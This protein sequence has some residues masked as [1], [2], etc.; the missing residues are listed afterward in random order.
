MN[1]KS[2]FTISTTHLIMLSFL[3]A[4]LLGAVLLSLPVSSADGQATP[5]VDALFTATTATCVT[6]LV[7]VPTAAAWSVFGHIVILI[8]IQLGG[9]GIIT[10]LAGITLTLNRK[11]GI[12]R[13]ILLQDAFNLDTL[14]GLGAFV[15]KVI[16]GT[17]IVEGIGALAYMTVF[18]PQFGARGIWI[19]VFT[20]ISAFCNAGIDIIGENSLIDYAT[21]PAINAI[22]CILI[23]VGGLG[24]IVWWDLI[25]VFRGRKKGNPL[26]HLTLH[27]KIV[28]SATAVLIFGGALLIALFEWNNSQTIGNMSVFDKLQASVFQSVTTRT[29][30]FAT[31]PQENLS[32]PSA[33]VS[34]LLMFIGGSPVGT[35]GGIKTVTIVVLF[36][37]ALVV[38]RQ[39]GEQVN[40]FGRSI[41]R[42][43]VS[44]AV[45]V[46]CMSFG[47]MFVSTVL[48]SAVT[49]AS[50]LDILYETVSAT[51]TVGLTRNLTP[52]LNTLGKLIITATMYLGRVGPISL[53]I[54][55]NLRKRRPSIISNPVETISVG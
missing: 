33:F 28:L 8:L 4:I 14:F 2:K 16:I 3:L 7:V 15:K 6:G 35:A 44:K 52:S 1:Q 40:M 25:R 31:V 37:A 38:V 20:S 46:C 29:A 32:N 17:F 42:Q 30:G 18:V 36:A 45:G 49:D 13:S 39:K 5:F 22:T 9:L 11:M 47:I 23:V 51:A 34:L 26:R 50:A 41:T 24:Y 12:G 54:A 19:S 43:A 53:M 21:N 55:F 10:V 48:L 27:S